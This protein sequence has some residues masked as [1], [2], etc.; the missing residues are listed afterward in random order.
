MCGTNHAGLNCNAATP[1][2]CSAFPAQPV[3]VMG[4]RS[5]VSGVWHHPLSVRRAGA[6]SPVSVI[7]YAMH[8][9]SGFAQADYPTRWELA[10][11]ADVTLDVAV[12]SGRAVAHAV[13]GSALVLS[14]WDETSDSTVTVYFEGW[15]NLIPDEYADMDERARWNH[16]VSHAAGRAVVR[17]PTTAIT[18]VHPD[19]LVV[20]GRYSTA[21]GDVTVFD[22]PA[23]S[24]WLA[25][26]NDNASM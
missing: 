15:V 9:P 19:E 4:L 24:A 5:G 1:T 22:E 12:P 13:P 2:C 16:A 14:P 20:V 6:M 11:D 18:T 8:L 21:T 23:L 10:V 25:V 7:V 3:F 26:Q 17:Y